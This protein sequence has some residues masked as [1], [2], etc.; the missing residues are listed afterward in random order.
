MFCS[1]Y[2]KWFGIFKKEKENQIDINYKAE[3]RKAL[4][5]VK[6]SHLTKF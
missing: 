5:K 4:N 6:W 1:L 3:K 2:H